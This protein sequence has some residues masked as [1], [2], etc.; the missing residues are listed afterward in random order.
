VIW[1]RHGVD[2]EG[3]AERRIAARM[4][5]DDLATVAAASPLAGTNAPQIYRS[6]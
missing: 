2:S 6:W 5:H 1:A 4:K 3:H